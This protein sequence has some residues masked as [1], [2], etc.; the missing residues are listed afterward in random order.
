MLQTFKLKL[1]YAMLLIYFGGINLYLQVII[2]S[3]K[4]TYHVLNLSQQTTTIK[5]H[6]FFPTILSYPKSY[7]LTSSINLSQQ[8][9]KK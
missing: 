9:Q 3:N 6:V 1:I 4:N 8:T 5:P 2:S 7:S